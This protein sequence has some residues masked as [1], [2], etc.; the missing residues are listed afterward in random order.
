MDQV[1]RSL[2][3]LSERWPKLNPG[4]VI[5]GKLPFPSILINLFALNS[6]VLILGQRHCSMALA[7]SLT[8]LI[9]IIFEILFQEHVCP[10]RSAHKDD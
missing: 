6:S 7:R 2:S 1:F 9:F 8:L 5:S 4:D 3:M 10:L